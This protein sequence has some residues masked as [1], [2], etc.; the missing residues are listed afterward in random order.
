MTEYRDR[1]FDFTPSSGDEN[2]G[3]NFEGY[4]AVFNQPARIEDERGQYDE[5]ISPGAFNK[6]IRG[7]KPLFMFNHGKHPLWADLPIGRITELREDP[8]GLY[9][10]A[11]MLGHDFFAPLREAIR[12]K[13]IPGMSFR[14]EAIKSDWEMRGRG[15]P[16]LRVLKEVRVPELGP[17][18]APAYTDATMALR[19]IFTG[20]DKTFPGVM[21]IQIVG[22]TRDGVTDMD[23]STDPQ[24]LIQ[25]AV[26]ERW[27]LRDPLQWIEMHDDYMIF[28]VGNNDISDHRGLWRVDFTIADSVPTLSEPVQMELTPAGSAPRSLEIVGETRDTTTTD[29]GTSEEAVIDTSGEAAT[30]VRTGPLTMAQRRQAIRQIQLDRR[31]IIRKASNE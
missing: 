25:Q 30:E 15:Q 13:A 14:F 8:R 19:S 26:A 5:V 24:T 16:R 1:E 4:A 10:Q 9:V 18:I 21:N 20:L 3:L 29:L 31:R 2:D 12:E 17:V 23:C 28:G 22:E 11:R 27:S 6:T 7:S